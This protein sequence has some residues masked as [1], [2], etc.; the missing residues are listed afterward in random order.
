MRAL[1]KVAATTV[2]ATSLLIGGLV[3]P[4]SAAPS[5]PIDVVSVTVKPSYGGAAINS[6]TKYYQITT[7]VKKVGKV[8]GWVDVYG[9]VY[10]GSKKVASKI[11]LGYAYSGGQNFTE[12]LLAKSSWGRGTFQI[13]NVRTVYAGKTYKDTKVSGGKFTMKSAIDGK[14]KYGNVVQVKADGK[15]KTVK[16]GVK[17]YTVSKGWKPYAG[18][19]VKIQHKVGGKW[20]TKKTV[21]LNKKG[22]ATYKFS[23]SKRVK[24]RVFVPATSQVVGGKSTAT[25]RV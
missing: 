6:K 15:K 12:Y 1:L 14:L 5:T 21:K 10:R 7:K 23:T 22:V 3:A 19:K 16:V 2:A 20:K 4:A 13:K 8:D 24:Y 11:D 9:D 17:K 18:K 25:P